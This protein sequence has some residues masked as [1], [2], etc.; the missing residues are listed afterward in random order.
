MAPFLLGESRLAALDR[1]ADRFRRRALH[2]Q[3]GLKSAGLDCG[4]CLV[5]RFHELAPRY[6]HAPP[7]D[8]GDEQ[9]DHVLLDRLCVDRWT[10]RAALWLEDAGSLWHRNSGS[11][12]H[13]P[14]GRAV[15]PRHCL[16]LRRGR[17]ARAIPL[18]Q[19]GL[20]GDLRLP[21]LR[22]RS[23]TRYHNR[24][25]SYCWQW[26]LY[27]VAGASG[28]GSALIVLSLHFSGAG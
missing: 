24:R 16:P 19:L 17:G 28:K 15:F 13:P 8:D 2:D 12:R 10:V 7:L 1:G 9:F 4:L 6:H 18:L 14:R 26:T 5:C 23:A 27:L 11:D 25:C 22:R 3:A 20:G 21:L